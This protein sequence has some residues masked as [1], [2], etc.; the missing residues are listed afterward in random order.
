MER[1]ASTLI[2]LPVVSL[3][4]GQAVARIEQLVL[5]QDSLA[6][7]GLQCKNL[8]TGHSLL[9]TPNDI[10]Q[11]ATDCVIIDHEDELTDPSEIVRF[12]ALIK[13]R[14]K[15]L[16]KEVVEDSGQKLGRVDDYSINLDS[17]RVQK[18]RLKHSLFLILKRRHEIDRTQIID[19]TPKRIIVR[20]ATI[21]EP[22][23]PSSPIVEAQE[24]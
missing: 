16:G 13:N 8:I 3:Q 14:F 22:L 24:A 11:L 23:I 1:F 9:L 2:G 5:H 4:T 18:L 19:V 20:S 12:Q 21:S 6:L 7:I 10:R 15:L 17:C